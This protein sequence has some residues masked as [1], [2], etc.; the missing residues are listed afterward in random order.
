MSTPEEARLSYVECDLPPG[1]TIAE[2]RRIRSA[3]SPPAQTR[4]RR[5][6]C[7]IR[8]LR[9]RLARSSDR[10]GPSPPRKP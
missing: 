9:C 10:V 8:A 6:K 5:L 2:Y 7:R 1:L 4:R 3:S